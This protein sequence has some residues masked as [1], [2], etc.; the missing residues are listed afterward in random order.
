[1]KVSGW[2]EVSRG[3]GRAG[4]VRIRCATPII[5]AILDQ[6]EHST[7]SFSPYNC[8]DM[9]GRGKK[10]VGGEQHE[11]GGVGGAGKKGAPLTAKDV[12]LCPALLRSVTRRKKEK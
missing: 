10:A 2:V 9:F 1:M 12:R 5:D 3:C 4:R 11:R 8:Q 6:A 7:V